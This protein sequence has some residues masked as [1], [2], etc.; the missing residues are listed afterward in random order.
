MFGAKMD[1]SWITK[2]FAFLY[3]M[4]MALRAISMIAGSNYIYIYIFICL[5]HLLKYALYS[6]YVVKE[7]TSFPG[8][9]S[10]NV[11]GA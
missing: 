1:S 11:C 4:F 3:K 7:V 2:C 6:V 8:A 10:I 9:R 5:C